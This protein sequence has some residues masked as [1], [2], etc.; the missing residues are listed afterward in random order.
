MSTTQIMMKT[1]KFVWLKLL[2]G[3]AVTLVSGLTFWLFTLLGLLMGETGML[4]MLCIW[5]AVFYVGLKFV[6]AYVG[7]LLKAGHVA[8]VANL[9]VHGDVEGDVFTFG[10]NS[11][12][13]RF[14]EANVYFVI[15]G[16]VSGA[17]RQLQSAVGTVGN[18]L[19]FI[20]GMESVVNILQKF[21]GIALGYV[22]ECCLGYCFLKKEE[23][24]FK[25]SCDGVVIYFQ[26]AKDII[27]NAAKITV[28]VCALTFLAWMV[29]YV[30]LGL[31]FRALNWSMLICAILCI[32]VAVTLKIAFIDSYIMCG[33]MKRYFEVAP[34]TELSYDL[35]DKLC[36]LSQKFKELF[37]KANNP[38][39]EV[40]A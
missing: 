21:I 8:A 23:N 39:E 17:V 15:D 1:M 3:L 33:M 38:S 13:E 9:V 20:P 14:K 4:I 35:Y 22:D 2:L 12:K 32:F 6:N 18:W 37:T 31:L 7:Y 27:L 16:L 26:H 30:V 19:S 36:K 28:V 5:I 29:P 25:A 11:V 34:G 10:V 40:T 24:A